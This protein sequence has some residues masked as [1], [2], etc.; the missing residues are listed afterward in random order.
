MISK[1]YSGLTVNLNEL[2]NTLVKDFAEQ[3]FSVRYNVSGIDV[4]MTLSSQNTTY[5]VILLVGSDFLMVSVSSSI[6]VFLSIFIP[7]NIGM[8][9]KILNYVYSVAKKLAVTKETVSRTTTSHISTLEATV[10]S[11][12]VSSQDYLLPIIPKNRADFL[13]N[14]LR[15]FLKNVGVIGSRIWNSRTDGHITVYF[16]GIPNYDVKEKVKMIISEAAG[17][18]ALLGK[19]YEGMIEP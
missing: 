16:R 7:S 18:A 9:N 6:P 14:E 3:G 11:G 13:C 5:K 8:E 12:E 19:S 17:V 2:L 1:F 10:G 4:N 15:G